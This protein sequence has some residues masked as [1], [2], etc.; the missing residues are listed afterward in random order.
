M[1]NVT[2]IR[3]QAQNNFYPW[4]ILTLSYFYL[5]SSFLLAHN[6]YMLLLKDNTRGYISY[7]TSFTSM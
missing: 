1:P 5:T 4:Q 7:P 6:W 3:S 2:N